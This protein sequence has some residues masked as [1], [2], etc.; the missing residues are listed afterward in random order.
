MPPFAVF[1]LHA[2]DVGVAIG[3]ARDFGVDVGLREGRG[4]EPGRFARHV[5]HGAI[6]PGLPIERAHHH[7]ERAGGRV[8]AAEHGRERARGLRA[9]DEGAGL[10]IARQAK[11]GHTTLLKRVASRAKP[12]GAYPFTEGKLARALQ[13]NRG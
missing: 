6:E 7:V 1:D 4:R 2:P 3:K 10:H 11:Y 13:I 12:G 9:A 8:A 5:A